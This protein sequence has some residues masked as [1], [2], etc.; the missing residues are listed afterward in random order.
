ME[1]IRGASLMVESDCYFVKS[2]DRVL[3]SSGQSIL[4]GDD[5]GKRVE[6]RGKQ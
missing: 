5:D 2:I 4:A 6:D 3:I 1:M